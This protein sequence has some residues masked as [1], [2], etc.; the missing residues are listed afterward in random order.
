[1]SLIILVRIIRT[2]LM[3]ILISR[4]NLRILPKFKITYTITQKYDNI[5]PNGIE[6][7]NL[8]PGRS[9]TFFN[10]FR[11][12]IVVVV[13]VN[14]DVVSIMVAD[15]YIDETLDQALH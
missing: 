10:G 15:R 7:A 13:V 4:N 3:I 14:V 12:L 2:L 5:N 11:I 9:R 6:D 1:M 8:R